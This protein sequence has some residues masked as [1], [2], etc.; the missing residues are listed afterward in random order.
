MNLIPLAFNT[1]YQPPQFEDDGFN[2]LASEAWYKA[3]VS[4]IQQYF[5]SF[6]THVAD[7][8][9]DI[10]FLDLFS[11]NGFFS[12][13]YQREI[14]ANAALAIL[15]MDLPVKK[16]IFCERN[17]EDLK[18]LKI[19]VNKFY[20]S[21][22]VLILGD[23]PDHLVEKFSYYIPE[24]KGKY[25]VAVFC[26]VEPFSL[27]I[28]YPTLDKMAGRGYTFLIPYLLPLNQNR[29][30]RFYTVEKKEKLKNFLK[31]CQEDSFPLSASP[32]HFYKKLVHIHQNNLLMMGLN[33]TLL[34][35]KLESVVM[36]VPS[37]YLGL[38][39]SKF[40]VKAIHR[41]VWGQRQQQFS[42]FEGTV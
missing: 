4:L 33:S 15:G 9:D 17:V 34:T 32:F 6:V 36:D 18:A 26:L 13:G 11:G 41:E 38:Y 40:S 29:N 5:A 8:V 37:Y 35:Q 20:R 25:R 14:Y 19:R 24:D 22:N 3:K 2:I 27:D 12:L 42:L 10:I 30:V 31:I 1:L 21:K 39:S 7:R 16:Y 23:H 28:A